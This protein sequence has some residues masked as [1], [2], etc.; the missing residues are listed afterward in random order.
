MSFDRPGLEG[1]KTASDTEVNEALEDGAVDESGL[2]LDKVDHDDG[3]RSPG[4]EKNDQRRPPRAQD[5]TDGTGGDP[6]E[7]PD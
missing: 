4:P 3:Q 5:V 6:V 7:P 2:H 1:D